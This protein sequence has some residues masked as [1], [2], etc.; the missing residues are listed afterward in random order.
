MHNIN[1]FDQNL[2]EWG[3]DQKPGMVEN[4]EDA[5]DSLPPVVIFELQMDSQLEHGHEK[6]S[7]Q[8]FPTSQEK[9]SLSPSIPKQDIVEDDMDYDLNKDRQALATLRKERAENCWQPD[10][11]DEPEEVGVAHPNTRIQFNIAVSNFNYFG[12]DYEPEDFLRRQ[13][14]NFQY[15][16]GQGNRLNSSVTS[17]DKQSD[18]AVFK[19]NDNEIEQLIMTSTGSII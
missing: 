7:S 17:P 5:N 16:Q 9:Q 1:N 4:N 3:K 6:L 12:G 13:K 11:Q 2:V 19:P 8:L 18:Q 10:L 15:S 14:T